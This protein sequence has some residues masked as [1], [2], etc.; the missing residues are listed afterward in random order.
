MQVFE[1]PLFVP[2]EIVI[3]TKQENYEVCYTSPGDIE[4]FA[5]GYKEEYPEELVSHACN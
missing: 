5:K 4:L 1:S 3:E 2:D